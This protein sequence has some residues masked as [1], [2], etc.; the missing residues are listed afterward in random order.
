MSHNLAIKENGEYSLVTR[1][2]A[3]HQL[4][5]VL[6]RA[7]TAQEALEQS[8]MDFDVIKIKNQ[9]ETGITIPNSYSLVRIDKANNED[10]SGILGTCAN[11]YK[12]LQNQDMFSFFDFLVEKNQAIYE[13]AGVLGNGERCWILAKLPENIVLGNNDVIKQY[14]LITNSHTG[15]HSAL[16][17]ITPVRAVCENTLN[18]AIKGKINS[19]SIRHFSNAQDKLRQA[20]EVLG[21]TTQYYKE[22]KDLYNAMIVKKINMQESI[23]FINKVMKV[24]ENEKLSTKKENQVNKVMDLYEI[25]EGAKQAKG[26]VWGALNAVVEYADFY[27]TVRIGDKENKTKILDQLWFGEGQ[28]IKQSAMD[29]AQNWVLTGSL[30]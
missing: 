27:K 13:T 21:F 17:M 29:L 26:T 7:F 1:D 20:H 8:G 30:N 6:N 2:P 14:I 23:K 15:K 24:S 19:V 28:K 4:G 25:G 11:N 10:G 3:W 18:T 16:A 12:I 5:T 9:L 22:L